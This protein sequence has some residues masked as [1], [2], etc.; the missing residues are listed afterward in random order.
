MVYDP[1]HKTSKE[2]VEIWTALTILLAPECDQ[3]KLILSLYGSTLVI[4]DKLALPLDNPCG[5]APSGNITIGCTSR[6]WREMYLAWRSCDEDAATATP[7]VFAHELGHLIAY[8]HTNDFW[9]K[10]NAME[11]A[12]NEI[13]CKLGLP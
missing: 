13:A 6:W 11:R 8:D 4:H 3:E 7:G 5:A 2:T 1:S 12:V 9:Y 10:D